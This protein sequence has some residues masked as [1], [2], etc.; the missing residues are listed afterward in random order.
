MADIN[1][2]DITSEIGPLRSVILRRPGAEVENITPDLMDR[3]LFD[4]IPYLPEAQKEHDTFAQTLRD[5]GAEVLYLEDLT[6]QALADNTARGK[7]IDQI[8]AESHYRVGYVHD[9]LKRYLLS[10]EPRKMVQNI[11]AGVRKDEIDISIAS[12][13]ELAENANYPFLLEPMPNLYFTR[14]PAAVIG[15]G[16]LINHMAFHA[17]K[18]ES[19]FM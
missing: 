12:L 7:F 4:D 2:S 5:A 17:R 1:R 18:R 6:A 16:V 8:L 13:E 19:L 15:N 14:D 10:L 3:L 11:M 9:G